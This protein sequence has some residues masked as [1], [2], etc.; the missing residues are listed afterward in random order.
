MARIIFGNIFL[1]VAVILPEKKL[2]LY[3]ISNFLFEK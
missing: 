3:R 2:Q 1:V